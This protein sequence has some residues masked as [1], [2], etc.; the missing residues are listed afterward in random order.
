MIFED[1]HWIDLSSSELLDLVVERVPCLPV[2]LE[3]PARVE[4]VA[5]FD[6]VDRVDR[7]AAARAA[8]PRGACGRRRPSCSWETIVER[9]DGVPR[10]RES[11]GSVES[12][13][14]RQV[15]GRYGVVG[16]V[17]PL[18]IPATLQGSLLARLDRLAPV[19]EIAQAA[20]A[21][22]REFSAPLVA[23]VARRPVSAAEDALAQLVAAGLVVSLGTSRVTA[24]TFKHALVQEA[25]Y[26][27]LLRE[28]RRELHARI[29]TVLES[30]YPEVARTRPEVLARHCAA[31]GLNTEAIG[32]YRR[33]A[34]QAM[35]ASANAEAIA[36]L[37]RGLELLQSLPASPERHARELDFQ[38]ALGAPLVATRGWGAPET[39]AAYARARQ[40][41]EAMGDTPELFQSLMGLCFFNLVRARLEVAHEL[42]QQLLGLAARLHDDEL[43]MEARYT[44]GVTLYWLGKPMAAVGHLEQGLVMYDAE[45]HRGHAVAYGQ[46]P[47]LQP[48]STVSGSL[49]ARLPGP[50]SRTCGPPSPMLDIGH[51]FSLAFA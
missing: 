9:T 31:A 15:A 20:A 16:A 40:L 7:V 28:R 38:T 24:Y 5:P 41:C 32:Y 12:G 46:D 36:H 37:T 45:R 42:S 3:P 23:A 51:A 25:A 2:L 44:F 39:E 22:G 29:S 17:P 8:A 13:L 27:T 18:A 43:T 33:A 35:A 48:H 19:R 4:P 14:L 10:S 21:I 6:R 50:T 34:A 30:E 49:V 26:S 47:R 1:V 11:P